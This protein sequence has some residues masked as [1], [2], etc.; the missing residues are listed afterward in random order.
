MK[1]KVVCEGDGRS[2]DSLT[3]LGFVIHVDQRLKRMKIKRIRE[4]L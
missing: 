2:F 1:V 4:I 3:R